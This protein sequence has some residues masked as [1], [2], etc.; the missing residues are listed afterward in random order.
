MKKIV[1]LIF[2]LVLIIGCGE[3]GTFEELKSEGLKKFSE[4]DYVK[5]REYLTKALEDKP[6]DKD[7]LYFTGMSY[8]REYLYDSALFYLKRA[9]LLFP[10]D[11]EINSEIYEVALAVEDWD[12]AIAAIM[13]LVDTGDKLESYYYQLA[14]LYSRIDYPLNIFYYLQRAYEKGMDDPSRFLQYANAA[15]MVDS[16]DL[17]FEIIDSAI[18]R[19]GEENRFLANK[20]KYYAFKDDYKTAEKMMRTVLER[21]TADP[22]IKFNLANILGLQDSKKKKREALELYRQVKPFIREYNIDSTIAALEEK[23]K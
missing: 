9:D 12:Y 4:G 8:K 15:A 13:T 18:T 5:A 3:P 14:D 19:F 17:A 6:S 23:L 20:A 2:L 10:K 7:L 21:D 1:L 11:R 22:G 16:L